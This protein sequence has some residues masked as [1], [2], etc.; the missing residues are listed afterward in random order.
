MFFPIVISPSIIGS[1]APA[2][3]FAGKQ[4]RPPL[5]AIPTLAEL[6]PR[7]SL[8]AFTGNVHQQAEAYIRTIGNWLASNKMT[9]ADLNDREREELKLVKDKFLLKKILQKSNHV[10][11]KIL[12][13]IELRQILGYELLDLKSEVSIMAPNDERITQSERKEKKIEREI[14][15]NEG[16]IDTAIENA[17]LTDSKQLDF[18]KLSYKT[19]SQLTPIKLDELKQLKKNT[20]LKLNKEPKDLAELRALEKLEKEKFEALKKKRFDEAVGLVLQRWDAII[21]T[22]ISPSTSQDYFQKIKRNPS[23]PTK[24]PLTPQEEM[25]E[26]SNLEYRLTQLQEVK[27]KFSNVKAGHPV[28]PQLSKCI[29]SINKLEVE[30]QKLKTGMAALR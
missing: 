6:Y 22:D 5:P 16:I 4:A 27:Q 19:Y 15:T 8:N 14:K 24:Q 28:P 2:L 7:I 30:I 29:E 10:T 1:P 12:A 3:K 18:K 17:K 11:E 21:P 23:A 13:L 9:Y 26:L 25:I 20:F